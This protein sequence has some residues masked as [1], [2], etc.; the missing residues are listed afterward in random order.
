MLKLLSHRCLVVSYHVLREMEIKSP[1]DFFWTFL[2]WYEKKNLAYFCV[3]LMKLQ[4]LRWYEKRLRI[5]YIAYQFKHNNSLN[6]L[7]IFLS[8]KLKQITEYALCI[9]LWAWKLIYTIKFKKFKFNLYQLKISQII[10]YFFIWSNGFVFK[11]KN[12]KP[13]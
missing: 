3:E 4:V 13:V 7:W 8:S 12:Q 10:L 5:A 2:K 11:K 9:S 1:T 6:K